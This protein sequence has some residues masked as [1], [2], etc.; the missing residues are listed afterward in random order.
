[1]L[2]VSSSAVSGEYVT[3]VGGGL[4]IY[5][6]CILLTFFCSHHIYTAQHLKGSYPGDTFLRHENHHHQPT[7]CTMEVRTCANG[8]T[9]SRQGPD[10]TFQPSCY[11]RNTNACPMDIKTCPD[12]S[13]RVRRGENCHFP[14]CR[15][16]ATACPMDIKT[17]PDGTTRA[18]R[19]EN[20]Q[21]VPCSV[22]DVIDEECVPDTRPRSVRGG[23][24]YR[25]NLLDEK[26]SN[27]IRGVHAQCG[28]VDRR[29]YQYGLVSGEINDS[30][31]C[32]EAC[33]TGTTDYLARELLGFE[34]DCDN[35]E[36]KCLYSVGVLGNSE[37][38]ASGNGFDYIDTDADG[39]GS[40]T[41]GVER[42]DS[43]G[44]YCFKLVGAE[45]LEDTIE[46][47]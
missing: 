23:E 40:I 26:D 33:V 15:S 38:R 8:I 22:D 32:S 34:Y 42:R 39:D 35:G 30:T 37:S 14:K 17:C 20:C 29:T 43:A 47:A 7:P 18:R 12:G 9:Q 21:F 11:D 45:L 1:M 3:C 13:T 19:G 36:C 4:G 16:S 44:V 24:R 10:C 41:T 31:Q 25:F 2:A 28:D 46:I 5:P 27:G 6:G